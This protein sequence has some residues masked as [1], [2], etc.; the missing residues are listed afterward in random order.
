MKQYYVEL[1]KLKFIIGYV[2]VRM[3]NY[4]FIIKLSSAYINAIYIYHIY[5]LPVSQKFTTEIPST[6][7][8]PIYHSNRFDSPITKRGFQTLISQ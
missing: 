8:M 1:K 3:F 7:N 2:C 6:R 5:I 4:I